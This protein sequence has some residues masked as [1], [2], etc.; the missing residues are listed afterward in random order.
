MLGLSSSTTEE[1]IMLQTKEHIEAE[2]L[3]IQKI[4]ILDEDQDLT[5]YLSRNEEIMIYPG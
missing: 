1:V 5:K 2:K 3:K 4:I